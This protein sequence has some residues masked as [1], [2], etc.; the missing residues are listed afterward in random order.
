MDAPCIV[1]APPGTVRICLGLQPGPSGPGRRP[2][3]STRAEGAP[4]CHA[5]S[6]GRR[7][8]EVCSKRCAVVSAGRSGGIL[9]RP[10]TRVS[11]FGFWP[12]RWA[13]A[14]LQSKRKSGKMSQVTGRAAAT[15]PTMDGTPPNVFITMLWDPK[16]DKFIKRK[17]QG[18]IIIFVGIE[19]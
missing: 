11:I 13:G 1:L 18:L 14:P 8:D 12:R 17:F 2:N 6:A 5:N 9:T 3:I 7:V 15:V 4:R 19:Y 16:I 10:G